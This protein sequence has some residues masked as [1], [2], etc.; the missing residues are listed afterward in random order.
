MPDVILTDSVCEY[1]SLLATMLVIED[2]S[3]IWKRLSLSKIRVDAMVT[4]HL[5]SDSIPYS[6]LVV[7]RVV[8]QSEARDSAIPFTAAPPCLHH[9]C[10]PS[11]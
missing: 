1:Y 3:F 2:K 9:L 8:S 10:L 4:I 5:L 7:Q 6:L 11:C